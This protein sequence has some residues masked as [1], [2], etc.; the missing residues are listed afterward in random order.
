MHEDVRLVSDAKVE[1]DESHAAKV[2]ERRYYEQNQHIFPMN[3]W[4]DGQVLLWFLPLPPILLVSACAVSCILAGDI[5][6]HA[7]LVV[8]ACRDVYDPSHV[9]DRFT[10]RD[11]MKPTPGAPR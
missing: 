5:D 11:T 3:R 7:A 8:D 2:L 4:S 1:K 6:S 9:Y 10:I